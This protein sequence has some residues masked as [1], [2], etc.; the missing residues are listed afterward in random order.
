[1][2]MF[3]F[4]SSCFHSYRTHFTNLIWMNGTSSYIYIAYLTIDSLIATLF[5]V[6][7]TQRNVQQWPVYPCSAF[8]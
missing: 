7:S 6:P 1:M 5:T 3:L 2:M 8:D 4:I